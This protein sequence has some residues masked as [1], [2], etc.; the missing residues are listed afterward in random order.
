M[1]SLDPQFSICKKQAEKATQLTNRSYFF[2][3][4]NLNMS[5][6]LL[7]RKGVSEG[8]ERAQRARKPLPLR[9]PSQDNKPGVNSRKNWA[10]TCL[11]SRENPAMP[12]STS[13]LLW[14]V[15]LGISKSLL[16]LIVTSLRVLA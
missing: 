13:E 15:F 5:Y 1:I 16:L 11:L 3:F 8:E 2:F 12:G 6:F 10:L 9:R 14:T 7:K 4:F